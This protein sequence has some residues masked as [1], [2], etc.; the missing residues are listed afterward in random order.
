MTV[1]YLLTLAIH[2]VYTSA[3]I[4]P[5]HPAYCRSCYFRLQAVGILLT[6]ASAVSNVENTVTGPK[7]AALP[8]G[9]EATVASSTITTAYKDLPTTRQQ[10]FSQANQLS[11]LEEDLAQ[12]Q[13]I[14]EKFEVES[15]LPLSVKGYLRANIEFW[16]S[17]GAPYF[18]L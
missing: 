5:S 15:G 16:K 18:I 7:T 11:S 17:I 14:V 3:H 2:T 8:S 9:Q 4:P 13:E 10:E 1:E 6:K 12:V